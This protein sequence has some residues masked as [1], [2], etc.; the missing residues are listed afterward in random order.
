MAGRPPGSQNKDKPFREA[1]RMELAE[2]GDDH[3]ALRRIARNLIKLAGGE[4]EMLDGGL[5][6]IK[7]IAD[8]MDGKPAQAIVGGDEDD[9]AINLVHRIERLIVRPS[10]TNG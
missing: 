6:A 1:L 10:N 8:R 9:P 2:I 5:G 3:K 4:S 7:E